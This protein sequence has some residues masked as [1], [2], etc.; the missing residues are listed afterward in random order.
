MQPQKQ[1]QEEARNTNEQIIL[2][3][4]KKF[5]HLGSF[6]PPILK[7]FVRTAVLQGSDILIV[8]LQDENKN[9]L[10]RRIFENTV[11]AACNVMLF[12][13]K[14]TGGK[15]YAILRTYISAME[16]QICTLLEN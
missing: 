6:K 8:D 11:D 12:N 2:A 5:L 4:L 16:E 15:H 14:F 7:E 13:P 9:K 3:K 1:T 10:K